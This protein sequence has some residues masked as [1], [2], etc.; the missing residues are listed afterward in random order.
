MLDGICRDIDRDPG[1]IMTSVHQA[2]TPGGLGELEESCFKFK[3]GGLDL[4]LF[5][6]PPPHTPLILQKLAGIAQRVG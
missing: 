1:E 2:A 6:L 3:E 5:Y 4:L